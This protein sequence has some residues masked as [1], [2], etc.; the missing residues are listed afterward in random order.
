[1]SLSPGGQSPGHNIN[2]KYESQPAADAGE[3]LDGAVDWKDEGPPTE[4]GS[5]EGNIVH[6]SP[7]MLPPGLNPKPGDRLTFVVSGEPDGEGDL[8]GYFEGAGKGSGEDEDGQWARG[9][10]EEMSPTATQKEAA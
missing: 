10:R 5:A 9:I 3:S 7:D 6:L 1:M 8:P 2:M 4:P